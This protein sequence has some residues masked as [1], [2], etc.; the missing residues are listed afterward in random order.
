MFT[1][2]VMS[3]HSVVVVFDFYLMISADMCFIM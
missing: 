2:L 1:R 3:D